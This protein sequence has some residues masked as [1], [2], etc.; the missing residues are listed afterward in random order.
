MGN[1]QFF[2][3]ASPDK[4]EELVREINSWEYEIEGKLAKGKVSPYI[5]EIKF[6]DVRIPEELEKE[7]VRDLGMQDMKSAGGT[8]KGLK[9]TIFKHLVKLIYLFTPYRPVPNPA[10]GKAKYPS[11]GWHY[12]FGVGKIKRK[13]VKV[14]GGKYRE[15]L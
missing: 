14:K 5:S 12:A 8:A 11:F 6:Y 9:L 2:Y 4:H 10:E 15:V 7:F 1:I 3:M 13:K